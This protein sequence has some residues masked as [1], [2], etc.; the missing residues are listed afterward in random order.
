[1]TPPEVP[2]LEMQ[3]ERVVEGTESVVEGRKKGLPPGPA[4]SKRTCRCV[5]FPR[6][7]IVARCP[8]NQPVLVALYIYIPDGAVKG[9]H[10]SRHIY[11]SYEVRDYRRAG[12]FRGGKTG[13]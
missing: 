4:H 9:R 13:L 10:R 12:M 6:V 7:S 11:D 3:T 8:S 1:M 2:G 5:L